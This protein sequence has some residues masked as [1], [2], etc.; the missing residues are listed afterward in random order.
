MR[1]AWTAA[2]CA[3]F[4]QLAAAPGGT[5][6]SPRASGAQEAERQSVLCRGALA[7]VAGKASRART[8]LG[9]VCSPTSVRHCSLPGCVEQEGCERV[10]DKER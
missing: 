1:R 3:A 7:T 6:L 9:R 10:E 8:A 5:L 4:S 2:G